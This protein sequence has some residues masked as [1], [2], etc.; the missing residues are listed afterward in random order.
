MYQKSKIHHYFP[1]I[2]FQSATLSPTEVNNSMNHALM[3]P[4]QPY[5]SIKSE[6]AALQFL[7]EENLE[8]LEVSVERVYNN[9]LHLN[10]HKAPGPDGLSTWV[11]N[12]YA[13]VLATPVQNILNTSYS[14]QDYP[15]CGKLQ[16]S[17]PPSQGEASH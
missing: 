17:H 11:L 9:L 6:H 10:K 13:E 2:V 7:L 14:K 4:L 15:Q 1:S 12:K 16:I 5:E 3:G 8:F